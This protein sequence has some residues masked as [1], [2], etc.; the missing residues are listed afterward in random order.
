MLYYCEKCCVLNEQSECVRCGKKNLRNPEKGDYCFLTEIDSMF[1]EMFKGILEE[2][3][4]LY[5]ASPSGYGIRAAF[6]L[7]PRNLRIFVG[8]EFFDRAKEL[9]DENFIFSEETENG[10]LRENLDKLFVPVRGEKK[11]KKALKLAEDDN[12]IDYCVDRIK[13]ADKIVNEGKITG[14]TKGGE[15]LFVYK[16]NE[17]IIINSVTY[18]IISA[19]MTKS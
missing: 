7:G 11:I 14:C 12:L 6:A 5:A 2:E 13:N 19:Q 1:G 10:N 9:F 18:E 17:L 8:Y 15:Y 16:N 4:I 3:N